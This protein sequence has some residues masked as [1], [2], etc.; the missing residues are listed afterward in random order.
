M[1][2]YL[3][4]SYDKEPDDIQFL[5]IEVTTPQLLKHYVFLYNAFLY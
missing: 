4:S 2:K 3:N 1:Q 5:Q